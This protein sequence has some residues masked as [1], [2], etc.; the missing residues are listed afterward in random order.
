M[1]G[2][3]FST[4][5]SSLTSRSATPSSPRHTTQ[6][7][8]VQEDIHTRN[9]LFPDPEA[10]YQHQSDQ[11]FPLTSTA[12]PLVTSSTNAF[13]LSP[14]VDLDLKDVRMV[15]M[16]EATPLQMFPALLYDSH[17]FVEPTVPPEHPT[18]TRHNSTSMQRTANARAVT[19][20]RRTSIGGPSKPVVITHDGSVPRNVG[21]A[22]DRR[23]SMSTRTSSFMETEGQRFSREYR[24]EINTVAN[25]MFGSS[26]IMAYK[27]TGT[28]VHIIPTESKATYQFS[29]GH[30]S[31]G[32][33]SLR[34]SKLAQSYTSESI[35]PV[36]SSA[37]LSS[38][39]SLS[40]RSVDRRRVLITRIFPVA[41]PA[42]DANTSPYVYGSEGSGGYP[43]PTSGTDD[44]STQK[45]RPRQ[46]RTPMYA[47]GLVITLPA[48][49]HPTS[50]SAPRAG[51][52]GPSSYTEH[53]SCPS[54]YS[55]PR[56]PW[57][58]FGH[59]MG[60]DSVESSV[61]SDFDDRI[62][63]ITQHWDIIM[64]TLSHVQAVVTKELLVM[65][66]QVDVASPDP[67]NS[68][69]APSHVR[70]PTASVSVSG[71][72][73]DETV[74]PYK[75]INTNAKLVQLLPNALAH[76]QVIKREVDA[77]RQRIVCGIR[78]LPVVT[79]QGRW[80]IW[81]EEVRWI[82]QWA[83]DN[84]AETF[85]YSLLTAFL[86][87][88]TEWLRDL[89]PE[90]HR[91]HYYQQKGNKEDDPPLHARTVIVAADKMAARRLVFLLSAFLPSN[92]QQQ[93][94]L[95]RAYRPGTSPS[96]DTYS[97]SPPPFA[98]PIRAES[99]RRK[100][101]R[102][103][104]PPRSAHSRTASSQAETLSASREEMAPMDQEHQH[105]TP[106]AVS[107]KTA[108][109][110]I[111][112]S[113]GGS[114][115]SSAATTTT[116][117]P[118]ATIPHFSTRR[119]V[120]G[121]GP[122]LRPGS[123]SSLAA[124]D[125][126][127]T[128]SK[129]DSMG[130]LSTSGSDLHGTSRWS[131]ISGLWNTKRRDNS[132][133]TDT[134]A[135]SV[136]SAQTS[137]ESRAE[138]KKSKLSE[139]V[140]EAHRSGHTV[141]AKQSGNAEGEARIATTTLSFETPPPPD[142]RTQESEGGRI[143]NPATVFDTIAKTS[144][145]EED[146]VID[147]D[148]QLPD[149]LTSSFGSAMSSPSSSGYLSTRSF[150][151]GLESF[152]H[153]S[154]RGLS[155]ETPLNVGG[156]LPRYHRDFALQAIPSQENLEAEIRASMEAEP[157]PTQ[158]VPKSGEITRWVTVSTALVVNATSLTIKRIRLRRHILIDSGNDMPGFES[159][160]MDVKIQSLYG[161]PQK[162]TAHSNVRVLDRKFDVDQIT[163]MDSMLADVLERMVTRATPQPR[164]R[165]ASRPSS[166]SA[167]RV[168]NTTTGHTRNSLDEN[169]KVPSPPHEVHRAACKRMIISALEDIARDVADAGRD[170]SSGET[171]P[172]HTKNTLREG[173]Q[174]WLDQAG[175]CR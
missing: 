31:L 23:S 66:R 102:R 98:P 49:Y 151:T 73:V 16:Q 116:V 123:S 3:L 138:A 165:P 155:E 101:K 110:P 6:L 12:V 57:T 124:D 81:R 45:S 107:L 129:G 60:T 109:L 58:A 13:D 46:K 132:S 174:S 159:A 92:Q 161:P 140:N 147:V 47:I 89:G 72:R 137:N 44:K 128:L 122:L 37:G 154:R 61:F 113:E 164:S 55:S 22:F 29:E 106:D 144:I 63:V 84:H 158:H 34:G 139:M 48:A 148:V 88:H 38:V 10:L 27:G 120:R 50:A 99:L 25:C 35:G 70:T 114:R 15:V 171:S 77:A 68:K 105:R 143:V 78:A 85:F 175:E 168:R 104:G 65:L 142:K 56:P 97:R 33:A 64:R 43:F 9:L 90:H 136:P 121:T 52:R 108:N 20:P 115:K 54:S 100:V 167:S 28:K 62:D 26:D 149:F 17:P 134:T 133:G 39:S 86:G 19:S 125:L 74:K 53:Q 30:G 87:S 153:Y 91:R 24:E 8:S 145:N 111:P 96:F 150:G 51:F 162:S 21:G 32:R 146:G 141:G 152:E 4:A 157:T 11:V 18:A 169:A 135:P 93:L 59:G 75:P 170:A 118:T 173:I 5:A 172:A 83:G 14:E 126:I 156:W 71:K 103:N 40:S 160:P 76:Q 119:T 82:S 2:R 95:P 79:R 42:S 94:P 127:R 1:L 67:T 36:P 41:L 117:T 69:G 80:G 166:R 131:M 7:E 112:G 163:T 130:Q